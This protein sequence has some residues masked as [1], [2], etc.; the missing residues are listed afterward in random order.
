MTDNKKKKEQDSGLI[1]T[2]K[3]NNYNDYV[4][5]QLKKTGDKEKQAQ[6]PWSRMEVKN[7]N[8]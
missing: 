1:S 7:Q 4:K 6:W 3:Y 5:F 2:H 8:I